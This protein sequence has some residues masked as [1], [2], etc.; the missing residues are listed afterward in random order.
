MFEIDRKISKLLSIWESEMRNYRQAQVLLSIE[1]L[2]LMCFVLSM[3]TILL[4]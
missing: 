4:L 1:C 3:V 2:D